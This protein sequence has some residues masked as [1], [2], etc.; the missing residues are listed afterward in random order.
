MVTPIVLDQKTFTVGE[1]QVLVQRQDVPDADK[2][3]QVV[4]TTGEVQGVTKI[5][6]WSY[7]AGMGN[8]D[9]DYAYFDQ[10]RAEKWVASFQ[11]FL[12]RKPGFAE[13]PA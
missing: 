9:C 7:P 6:T 8:C 12:V 13:Q 10:A 4:I 1:L 5:E 3:H 11:K 2:P